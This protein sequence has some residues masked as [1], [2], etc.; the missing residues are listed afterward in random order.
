MEKRPQRRRTSTHSGTCGNLSS[1]LKKEYC[2]PSFCASSSI[3]MQRVAFKMH[4]KKGC[5][6]EYKQRHS[7]IWPELSQLLSNAGISDYSI[8]LDEETD[9]LFAVQR[10]TAGSSQDLASNEIV[11]KWWQYMADIML[12]EEDS[13]RPQTKPLTEMF[14]M[15]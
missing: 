2:E 4:L 10:V 6:E 3:T 12:T 14:Y 7:N 13:V 8:F 5:S 1:E 15:K 11:Q 9:T